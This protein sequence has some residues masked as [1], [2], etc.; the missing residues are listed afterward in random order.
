MADVTFCGLSP[1]PTI[2]TRSAPIPVTP[3]NNRVSASLPLMSPASIRACKKPFAALFIALA[4]S[5][6][7]PVWSRVTTIQLAWTSAAELCET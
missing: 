4:A 6:N 1:L 5:D 7:L 3:G 2:N